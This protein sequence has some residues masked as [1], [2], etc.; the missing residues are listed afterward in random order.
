MTKTAVIGIDPGKSGGICAY[1]GKKILHVYACPNTLNMMQSLF[2]DIIIDLT[3]SKYNTIHILL[4]LVHAFPTD[5]RASLSKFMTNYGEWRGIIVSYENHE[6]RT[7]NPLTWMKYYGDRPTNKQERKKHLKNLAKEFFP[8][9]KV[10]LKTADAI[11]IAKYGFE[12]YVWD[13]ES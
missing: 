1:N 8:N 10:T 5:G 6:P 2:N 9:N 3:V 12:E 4:E 7:I 13:L 11:L